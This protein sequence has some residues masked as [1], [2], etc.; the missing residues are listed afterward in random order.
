MPFYRHVKT[1]LLKFKLYML[2]QKEESLV[3][4][5]PESTSFIDHGFSE[6]NN[7]L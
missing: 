1:Q 7:K 2:L 3:G 4:N 5:E 6:E